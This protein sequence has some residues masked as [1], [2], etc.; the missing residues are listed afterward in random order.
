[1]QNIRKEI[2]LRIIHLY[3][4]TIHNINHKPLY[5]IKTNSQNV[6]KNRIFDEKIKKN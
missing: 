1:M 6:K 2:Y 4:V 5:K 3:M